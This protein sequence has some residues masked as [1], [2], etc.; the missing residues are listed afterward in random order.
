MS[1]VNPTKDFNKHKVD[2]DLYLGTVV[3]N[4]D[5][6]K[7]SRVRVRVLELFGSHDKGVPDTDLPWCSP[8]SP[9]L[10]G[11]SVRMLNELQGLRNVV[12]NIPV[13]NTK[14][15]IRLHREDIYSPFYVHQ[16][17]SVREKSNLFTGSASYPRTYGYESQDGGYIAATRRGSS[18]INHQ[19]GTRIVVSSDGDVDI[20]VNGRTRFMVENDIVFNI[21]ED[22]EVNAKN[23]T[24]NIDEDFEVNANNVRFN[25]NSSS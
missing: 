14:V 13:V 23:I 2:G 25:R 1:L 9:V 6:L 4:N 5:P 10:Q 19:S 21:D 24:F 18:I 3:D 22:F 8:A 20:T 12:Y 15:L 17:I 11:T 7:V 16:T